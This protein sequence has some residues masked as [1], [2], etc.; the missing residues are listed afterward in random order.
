MLAPQPQL[1]FNDSNLVINN[2][3]DII[4]GNGGKGSSSQG[5][6]GEGIR[7]QASALTIN[8]WG[9]IFSGSGANQAAIRFLGSDSNINLRGWSVIHGVMINSGGGTNDVLNFAF[10]GV[11]PNAAA[12][13]SS[14]LQ[15]FMT[16]NPSTGSITFRGET[17]SW[18]NLT[19]QEHPTSYKAEATT[20][21]GKA[22]GAALDNFTSTPPRALRDLLCLIDQSGSALGENLEQLSPQVYQVYGDI[23]LALMNFT[24]QTIDQ[25]LDNLHDGTETVDT[26]GLGNTMGLT[27][28]LMS[29]VN[30]FAYS[31]DGKATLNEGKD[32]KETPAPAPQPKEWGFFAVGSGMWGNADTTGAGNA[33]DESF[34][35]WGILMGADA[36]MGEH[37]VAGLYGQYTHSHAELDNLGDSGEVDS[38]G[39]GVYLGWHGSPP[40]VNAL[41]NYNRNNYPTLSRSVAFD[42]LPDPVVLG[43]TN[44]DQWGGD[45]SGGYDFYVGDH[46]TIG[47]VAGI[48]YMHFDM[49]DFNETGPVATGLTVGEEFDSLRSRLGAKADYHSVFHHW[50]LDFQARAAWQHEFLDDSAAITGGFFGGSGPTFVVPTTARGRDAALCGVGVNASVSNMLTLF[51]DYDVQIGQADYWVQ[52]A[53]GGL[54]FD[55]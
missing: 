46:F 31:R 55:F 39:G 5:D 14:M 27:S 49:D 11:N 35:S 43:H 37:M 25:R 21:G 48:Q 30:T 32:G 6:A 50:A 40:Y 51:V 15:P 41:F 23:A 26:R 1:V 10:S 53:T 2:C 22:I 9:D 13:L 8:N 36:K 19:V 54:R 47:P 52:S 16:G 34:N 44:G 42:G 29:E 12:S 4:G 7:A 28:G 3:G 18:D 33:S 24:V 17:Y 45:V 20:P 38:Y